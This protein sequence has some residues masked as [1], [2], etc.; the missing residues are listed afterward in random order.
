MTHKLVCR[1]LF[2]ACVTFISMLTLAAAPCVSGTLTSYIALGN[3]G[4]T[5]G[6]DTFYNFQ[7][8]PPTGAASG[9]ATPVPATAITV[10]GLGPAGTSGAAGVA[11]L[12]TSDIG[13]DFEA[14]W[15][16]TAGQTLDDNIAFDVSVGNGAAAITDAGIV[17]DTYATGNGNVTVTEKGCSGLVFPCTQTWG[18]ATNNSNVVADTSISATGTLSVEKD[19]AVSGN[20]GTAGVLNVAD[21]FSSSE[22]PEPRALPLL[23]GLG[24]VGFA[25]RKKFQSENT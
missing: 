9:G 17:Q 3:T 13:L 24:L 4:C 5:I 12:L 7:L 2:L 22:V 20:D 14:V 11:P 15:A 23:L 16:A 1:V 8:L 6:G 21:V 19:I 25:L 18:V 10:E